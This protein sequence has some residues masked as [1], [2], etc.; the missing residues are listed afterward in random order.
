MS[1]IVAVP[2]IP[3]T[4]Q[5]NLAT[6]SLMN[7][8]HILSLNFML[9]TR[10]AVVPWPAVSVVSQG[11]QGINSNTNTLQLELL[12][13]LMMIAVALP[14]VSIVC[15]PP[16]VAST[17]E[18]YNHPSHNLYRWCFFDTK[19][20]DMVL[21]PSCPIVSAPGIH[22]CPGFA[23]VDSQVF[24]PLGLRCCHVS[25]DM[26]WIGEVPVMIVEVL[27]VFGSVMAT[28]TN[29]FHASVFASFEDTIAVDCGV[30]L[31]AFQ[32]V[33]MPGNLV[34]IRVAGFGAQ[35]LLVPVIVVRPPVTTIKSML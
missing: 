27:A 15:T 28:I 1:M 6:S 31:D 23:R 34:A 25:F 18:G 26:I 10:D 13:F 22:Q 33:S 4:S 9:A 5:R 11:F 29:R 24:H 2:V 3:Y 19:S 35:S 16:V 7:P 12:P 30:H 17:S 32:S 14:G 20:V 8:E 21:P